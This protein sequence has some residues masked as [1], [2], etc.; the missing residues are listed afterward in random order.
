MEADQ[1]RRLG[2]ACHGE[3]GEWKDNDAVLK[4][5]IRNL[6]TPERYDKDDVPDKTI[7]ENDGY[8]SR[9]SVTTR[10]APPTFFSKAKKN[11]R[12]TTS[13]SRVWFSLELM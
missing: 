8:R 1:Q 13:V 12:F 6:E 7:L 11:L 2:Q 9:W 5:S 10:R 4:G 3:M